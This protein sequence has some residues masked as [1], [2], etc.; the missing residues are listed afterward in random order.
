MLTDT[1]LFINGAWRPA[2]DGARNEVHD[3]A[4]GEVSGHHA[5]A[6]REDML[7]AVSAAERAFPLWRDTPAMER[8]AIMKR[9][10]ALLRERAAEVAA[11]LTLEMG[12]P[13]AEAETE[14]RS[15][16]D[17]LDWF[18]EEAR[19]VYGRVIPPR[20]PDVMQLALKQPVGPVAAFTPWNFPV[21][22]LVRKV[23]PALA[24]G[25][26]VVAK[27]PEDAP[28][29]P[30][31][32]A[33]VLSEAGLPAGVLNLLYGNPPDISNFLIPHPAIRKVSFTGSVPVG[34]Q[35]ASLAGRHMKRITMELGGHSPVLVFDDADIEDAARSI[36]AFKFRNAGQV[37][38]S[39]TRILV[40]RGIYDRFVRQLRKE[41]DKI[42]TGPGIDPAT[43]MGPLVSQ[44][45]I[46]AVGTLI[47]EAVSEGATLL[48]GGERMDHSGFFY[49]PTLL[50]NVPVKARILNEEPFGP[51]ALLAQFDTIEE[52]V[53]EANRLAYGLA[54]YAYTTSIRISQILQNQ[55]E[56]GML[57]INHTALGL[58]E[59]PLG[60][61]K[62]SGFGSE[63]GSE[64][65]ETY[66][67]TKL[68]TQKS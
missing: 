65:V 17:I 60:G 38:I 5:V 47:D 8:A 55:V 30:A 24:A 39:P 22:Q 64:A 35:L 12:K 58:P 54:A 46:E 50:E 53:T 67:F 33:E 57:A 44:R 34:K 41:V 63:G 18:A 37:C 49:R 13:I 26:T 9:A 51:V 59:L 52:A 11:I 29:S 56:T 25:C 16:A 36:A 43:V 66:L 2:S 3:P 7:E 19:R 21:S 4:T 1:K 20:S 42:V 40:Q 15:S 23:G 32:I 68:V 10:A 14:L 27:P 6:T 28:A 48:T 31:A 62:D 61:V 45:R